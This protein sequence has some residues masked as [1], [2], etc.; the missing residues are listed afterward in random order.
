MI[1]T[2]GGLAVRI[3]TDDPVFLRILRQQYAA[4]T[5]AETNGAPIVLDVELTPPLLQSPDEDLAVRFDGEAWEM[6]RGDFMARYDPKT[7]RGQVRQSANRHS[8][9]SVIRIIHSLELARAGSGFLLHAASAVRNGKAF[10]FSGVS[11]AGKTTLSRL[12]PPD[13]CLLTD[14]VSYVRKGDGGPDCGRKSGYQAFGT[15]FAGELG[16]AGENIHAPLGALYFLEQASGNRIG[17]LGRAEALRMLLRNILFFAQDPKLV[18]QVFAIAEDFIETVPVCRLSF[19]PE[20]LVWE[21][22]R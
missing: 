4:F 15:P 21:L 5:G 19:R 14:E 13:V 10:V 7:R 16:K 1:V 12:A 2:I 22:I 17:Q 6:R 11:G 9:D 8:I 3:A 20:A 18:E